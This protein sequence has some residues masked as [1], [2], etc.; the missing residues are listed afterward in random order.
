MLNNV[1]GYTFVE[2]MIAIAI[3]IMLVA[4]SSEFIVGGFRF[5]RFESEL[6]TAVTDARKAMDVMTKEIRGANSSAQG[7]YPLHTT[8]EQEVVFFSD[9][10]DDGEMEKVRYYLAGSNLNKEVTEPGSLNDYSGTPESSVIAYYVNNL[11][12]DVFRYY[13]EDYTQTSLVNDIRL[14]KI[15][16]K[17]NVT[18]GI[19]PDDYIIET[20]VSLR[21]L[22]N[23]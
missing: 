19:S 21:N 2:M 15:I 3:F 16:L 9:I 1:K 17:I 12:D 18:A 20:D 5:T 10:D 22:K 4:L 13:D 8:N 11:S 14:I 7:G 6:E 23:N